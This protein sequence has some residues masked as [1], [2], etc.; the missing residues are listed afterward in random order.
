ML[1]LHVT[2][3][4]F[5][6]NQCPPAASAPAPGSH[7]SHQNG[8]CSGDF[9]LIRV[10][11]GHFRQQVWRQF[12][13]RDFLRRHFQPR[14]ILCFGIGLSTFD[15]VPVAERRMWVCTLPLIERRYEYLRRGQSEPPGCHFCCT[16]HLHRSIAV[17]PQVSSGAH[18]RRPFVTTLVASRVVDL[19]LT[20]GGR[21]CKPSYS[22]YY[23]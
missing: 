10:A 14:G 3:D 17:L 18:F 12:Q 19:R 23:R 1:G 15:Y 9:S 4:S 22:A 16:R 13:S 8:T 20:A 7:T 11:P 6:L 21:W 5:R 2:P